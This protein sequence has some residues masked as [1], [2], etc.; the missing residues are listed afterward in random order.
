[1]TVA[2]MPAGVEPANGAARTETVG[3]VQMLPL[4]AEQVTVSK[5]VHKTRVR[6]AR[7]TRTRDQVVE[8][9]LAHDQVIVDR[10]PINRVVDAV[11]EVRQEGDVTILPVV[12]EIVVIERRLL[13]KEE[14][15]VRHVRTTERHRL[16]VAFRGADRHR[17]L[18]ATRPT[19]RNP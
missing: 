19:S 7:T 13:L 2:D 5:R 15:H 4:H 1:M 8:Q 10:I 12:E 3:D 9:D 6:V 16:D 17:G 11:P 14:V 18:T